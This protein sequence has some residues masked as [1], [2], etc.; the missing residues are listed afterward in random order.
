MRV[1]PD[2]T[3]GTR[4]QARDANPGLEPIMHRKIPTPMLVP[5]ALVAFHIARRRRAAK[6]AERSRFSLAALK[7]WLANHR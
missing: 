4:P 1:H 6:P 7:P 2:V 5:L 3:P